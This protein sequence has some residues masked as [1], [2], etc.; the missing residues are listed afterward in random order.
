[1]LVNPAGQ[2]GNVTYNM[3]DTGIAWPGERSKYQ[4]TSYALSEIVPPP[5]WLARFPDGYTDTNPPPDLGTD[6]HFIN[7]M[8]TAGLPTFRKLYF[9]NDNED[10]TG[11]QYEIVAYMSALLSPLLL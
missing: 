3:T 10:L 4:P 6:E 9:R 1:M 8:R 5:F 11:G 7:W 2:L